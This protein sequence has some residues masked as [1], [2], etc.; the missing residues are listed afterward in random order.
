MMIGN[1]DVKSTFSIMRAEDRKQNRIMLLEKKN[2][3]M[4]SVE[5]VELE[6]SN[7]LDTFNLNENSNSGSDPDFQ[8]IPLS[9]KLERN[10]LSLPSLALVADRTHVSDRSVAMIASATLKDA[11]VIT[12][13]DDEKV[14]DRS[15]VRRKRSKMRKTVHA[16]EAAGIDTVH[17]IFFDGKLD[18]T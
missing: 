2:Q 6:D 5:R 12:Q 14:I 15:K 10:F 11:G 4:N 18:E 16:S 17:C 1:T 7:S 8:P 3:S 9:S 13:T